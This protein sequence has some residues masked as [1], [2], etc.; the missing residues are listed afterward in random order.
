MTYA[1]VPELFDRAERLISMGR[2]EVALDGLS[3]ALNTLRD[4]LPAP[5][6]TALTRSASLEPLARVVHQDPFTR[7]A[8]EKPRGY[9]GDAV[10]MDLIYGVHGYA[11]AATDATRVGYAVMEWLRHRGA[12][13]S[14]RLRRE[15]IATLIDRLAAAKAD[16][17]V[18]AVAAGHFREAEASSAIRWGSLGRVVALDAD[19]DSVAEVASR[20]GHLGVEAVKGSVRELLARKTKIGTFDFVY[21][22]GLYD[23]LA[24]PVA[25]AL[26]VRLFELTNPGGQLLIPNFTPNCPDTGYMETFMAW[27]LIY[28]D[29]FD[30]TTLVSRLPAAEIDSYDIDTDRT[31]SIVYLLVRKVG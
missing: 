17:S 29:E 9:A 12:C 25:I 5:E 16:P 3:D 7:R 31:G 22:A 13:T 2:L 15:H 18:L 30:M 19:A 1:T 21:A 28:R 11:Q 8:F 4:D 26:T 20:Y 14:V 23:Y 10:M 27:N 6:W 24:D